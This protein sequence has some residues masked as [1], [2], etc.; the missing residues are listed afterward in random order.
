[1][2]QPEGLVALAERWER[3][4]IASERRGTLSDAIAADVWRRSAK[5]LREYLAA[6]QGAA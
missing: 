1:M 5:E 2:S 4:A 6:Q 3:C